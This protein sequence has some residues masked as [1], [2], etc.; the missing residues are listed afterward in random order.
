MTTRRIATIVPRALALLL[1][2]SLA[3]GCGSA[4]PAPTDPSAAKEYLA[5][6]L[7]AW[8]SGEPRSSL[9]DGSPSIFVQDPDW[10]RESKLLD[11]KLDGDGHP[12]GAGIQWTVPL[13]LATGAKT[14][15]RRAVYVVNVADETVAVRR[16]DMDF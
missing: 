12:L 11:Y 6:A 3:A 9:R 2:A 10:E 4:A 5:Q 1:A 13:T 8:K 14:V 7:D 16:Q 15:E